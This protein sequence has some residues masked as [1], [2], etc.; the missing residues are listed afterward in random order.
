MSLIEPCGEGR[1]PRMMVRAGGHHHILGSQHILA[2]ACLEPMTCGREPVDSDAS[3]NRQLEVA[4]V[5]LEIIGGLVL[6]GVRGG[7]AGEPQ[8]RQ[9]AVASR[10]EQPQ[11]IPPVSPRI[12]DSSGSGPG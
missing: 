11:R 10:R 2:A 7:R 8:S 5:G 9:L 3:A 4:G 12:S 6:G 1:N